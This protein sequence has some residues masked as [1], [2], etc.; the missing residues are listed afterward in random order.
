MEARIYPLTSGA[1]YHSLYSTSDSPMKL[2]HVLSQSFLSCQDRLVGLMGVAA[3][4]GIPLEIE[5]GL[6]SSRI[7][8]LQEG[9]KIANQTSSLAILGLLYPLLKA[10]GESCQ[11]LET[12]V[13]KVTNGDR[14]IRY[15]ALGALGYLYKHLATDQ[16]RED[17][18]RAVIGRIADDDNEVRCTALGVLSYM[19]TYLTTDQ[20]REDVFRAVIGRMADDKTVVREL[21]LRGFLFYRVYPQLTADQ[22]EEMLRAVIARL[23]DDDFLVRRA[24]LEA[25]S[26]LYPHLTTD[27]LTTDKRREEVYKA[28]ISAFFNGLELSSLYP[29]LTTDQREEVFKMMINREVDDETHVLRLGKLSEVYQHLTTNQREEV[30][31]EM[32]AGL[33]VKRQFRFA[34]AALPSLYP[35]LT[36]DQREEVFKVTVG[37]MAEENVSWPNNIVA[38]EVLS[39]LYP[40]LTTDDQREK[41]FKTVISKRRSSDWGMQETVLKALSGV[42]R[43]L[44]ADEE[45]KKEIFNVVFGGITDSDFVVRRAALEALGSLYPHLTR[46]EQRKQALMAV[47][48]RLSDSDCSRQA[49]DVIAES[50]SSALDSVTLANLFNTH[51][52]QHLHDDHDNYLYF[53]VLDCLSFCLTSNKL[54]LK[55]LDLTKILDVASKF[56]LEHLSKWLIQINSALA[57]KPTTSIYSLSSLVFPAPKQAGSHQAVTEE[58]KASNLTF[59]SSRTSLV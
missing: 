9:E 37:I 53:P 2:A 7:S 13:G 48:E 54:T 35:Y 11:V 26:S 34:P 55:Q 12:I 15:T 25:L 21:A 44:T 18:L 41:V 59:S 16:E 56:L 4:E 42:C 27:H 57:E 20:Q 36:T 14:Q 39:N 23:A 58:Q 30:F 38:L 24:A 49:V 17:V 6:V 46:D 50:I 31:R 43:Y 1:V 51:L 52:L 19:Y 32:I 5:E 40:Y 10:D 22:R 33:A 28:M 3:R 29:H 8:E 45:R 47:I